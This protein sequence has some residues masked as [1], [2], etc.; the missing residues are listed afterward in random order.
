MLEHAEEVED[1][2]NTVRTILTGLDYS[3]AFVETN[4]W[5]IIAAERKRLDRHRCTNGGCGRDGLIGLQCHHVGGDYRHHG[6]E[7]LHL[8]DLTTLCAICH[9]LFHGE[10]VEAIALEWAVNNQGLFGK[11]RA[12]LIAEGFQ[13]KDA[14][15]REYDDAVAA[16]PKRKADWR[17][18]ECA[19]GN[20]NGEED[21]PSQMA[22]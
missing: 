19:Q 5:K 18:P 20:G 14:L 10:L 4:Y 8:D 17:R 11:E 3:T 2:D 12:R 21:E 6:S 7:H 15:S 22:R 9:H 16:Q 1:W 13:V